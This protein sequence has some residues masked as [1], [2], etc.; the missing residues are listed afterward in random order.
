MGTRSHFLL[1]ALATLAA[2]C[3]A[4]PVDDAGDGDAG[5]PDVTDAGL[6]DAGPIGPILFVSTACDF[7]IVPIHT[8]GLCEVTIANMGDRDVSIDVVGFSDDTV[9]AMEPSGYFDTALPGFG[10]QVSVF[11]PWF[12]GPGTSVA[13]PLFAHPPAVGVTTGT[14]IVGDDDDVHE[15]LLKVTGQDH[16]LAVARIESVNGASPSDDATVGPLDNVSLS[17][18][19]STTIA[20]GTPLVAYEWWFIGKPATSHVELTTPSAMTTRFSFNSS[21]TDVFGVDVVGTYRIGLRVTD[22]NG[23][24]DEDDVILY[25]RPG[26]GLVFELTWDSPT[27]DLDLHLDREP[28]A[29]CS[30]NTCYSANCSQNTE[31]GTLPDWDNVPGISPGDPSLDIDDVSGFGPEQITLEV[32]QLGNYR[33]GV[34]RVSESAGPVDATV[35]V[36]I[37]GALWFEDM[38]AILG[39]ERWDVGELQL[40]FGYNPLFV[41]NGS[42]TPDWQCGM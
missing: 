40:L 37:D 17:A 9:V 6:V 27:E 22:A 24:S 15:V 8:F 11:V 30:A 26:P 3:T 13:L 42:V 18:D 5:K 21:G 1:L 31:T 39:H 19:A 14:F 7:G 33:V 34:H 25:A 29:S 32:P 35:R 10:T 20:D 38:R 23:L 41:P 4:P 12:I 28:Y 2:S 16:V 36:F